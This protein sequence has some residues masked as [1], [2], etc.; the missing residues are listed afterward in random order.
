MGSKKILAAVDGSELAT[1][2]VV[3]AAEL[4]AATGG[5]LALVTVV[6]PRGSLA[7]E[8]GATAGEI[9][10]ELKEE[11]RD[12]LATAAKEAVACPPGHRFLREGKPGHEICA[13]AREWGADVVVIGTH[14]R[15]GLSR[16]LMGSTAENVVRHSPCPVLVIPAS[17]YGAK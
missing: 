7:V 8:G 11:A 15:G 17:A 10:R 4:A 2:A 1:R 6:D 12:L 3:Q 16:V 14:G 13:S 9:L 5:E